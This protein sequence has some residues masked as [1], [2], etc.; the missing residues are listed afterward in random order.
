MAKDATARAKR[1]TVNKNNNA[2]NVKNGKNGKNGKPSFKERF[3]NFFKKIGE[4]FRRLKS[5][6]KKVTWPKF[7]DVL[8]NTGVVLLVTL[9]FLVVVGC[10]DL[11]LSEIL[12][13]LINA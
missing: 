5:E 8:K 10:F 9:I 12:K 6:L 4:G 3:V 13:A 7:K 1:N 11:G 2:K